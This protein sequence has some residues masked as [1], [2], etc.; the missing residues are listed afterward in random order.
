M[1]FGKKEIEPRTRDCEA[2]MLISI[3]VYNIST[4]HF[5]QH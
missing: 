5:K 2:K 3:G 1:H 4:N